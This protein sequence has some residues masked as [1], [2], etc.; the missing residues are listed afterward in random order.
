M[1]KTLDRQVTKKFSFQMA[2]KKR[3]YRAG[4]RVFNLLNTF[5]P[6]DV[7]SNLGSPHFGTFYRGVK[8]KLRAVFELGN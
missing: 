7:Q 2:G 4:I 3:R 5:N 1:Y 6:Q 8:R